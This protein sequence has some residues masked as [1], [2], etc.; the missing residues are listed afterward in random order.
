[1]LTQATTCPVLN[2]GLGPVQ[3]DLLGLVVEL[4]AIDLVV[5]GEQGALVGDLLCIIM[6]LL[7]PL[8]AAG[9]TTALNGIAASLNG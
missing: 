6:G 2:I 7:S 1:V 4:G 8:D 5:G 9:L 3:V